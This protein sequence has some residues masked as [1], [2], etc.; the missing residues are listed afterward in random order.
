MN[1]S[2]SNRRRVYYLC[3]SSYGFPKQLLWGWRYTYAKAGGVLV[4]PSREE[5]FKARADNGG[6]R[7]V[8]VVKRNGSDKNDEEIL[9]TEEASGVG[10]YCIQFQEE[11]GGWHQAYFLLENGL[12]L[13][14]RQPPNALDI[15]G[16]SHVTRHPWGVDGEWGTQKFIVG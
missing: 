14:N 15:H 10:Y 13:I 1:A 3:T 16:W 8:K 12:V 2:K 11:G 9:V 5:F 4:T 6:Q 7:W